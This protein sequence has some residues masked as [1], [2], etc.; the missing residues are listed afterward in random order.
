MCAYVKPVQEHLKL[1]F[2]L[3]VLEMTGIYKLVVPF[4]SGDKMLISD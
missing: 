1:I 2:V 4:A 3:N